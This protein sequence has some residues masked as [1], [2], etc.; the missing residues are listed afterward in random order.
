M[1]E[2]SIFN[3]IQLRTLVKKRFSSVVD[4]FTLQLRCQLKFVLVISF[5]FSSVSDKHVIIE[6]NRSAVVNG[7]S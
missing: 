1:N 6:V 3:N 2:N 4:I 5:F 7:I